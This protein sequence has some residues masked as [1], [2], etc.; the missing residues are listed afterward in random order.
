M[1]MTRVHEGNSRQLVPL[2][3]FTYALEHK[4]VYQQWQMQN[5]RLV[6]KFFLC[7]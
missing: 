2:P 6:S 1:Y 3:S 4:L 5:L 7:G